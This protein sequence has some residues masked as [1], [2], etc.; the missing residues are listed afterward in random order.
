[1]LSSLSMFAQQTLT[2]IVRDLTAGENLPGVN[3]VVKGTTNGTSTDFDGKFQLKNIKTG[4]V[5][6]FSY[7]GYLNKEVTIDINFNI[8]VNLTEDSQK[9]DEVVIIGYGTT[10]LKDA[11]GSV[12]AI[13]A[14]DFTKGNIVTPENLLS[15]RVAG[16]NITTS[17]APGSGSQ[18]TIRGG[19][20]LGA[21]NAPLIVIDGLPIDNNGTAGSRGILANI[22]PNDIESF[23]IL[24]DA[25][26]TAIYGSRASNGVII[27]VTK[28]GK[29]EFTL[30]YDTQYSFGK[31]TDRVDVFSADE[32]R[33]FVNS[34]PISGTTLDTSLLGTANTNWQDEILQSTLSTQHNFTVKG[35]IL[36]KI[37][38]RVSL[39]FSN[40]EGA[41][42]T[43]QFNR[44]NFSL[45][46]NP[47]FFKDHLKIGLNYNRAHEDSRFAA[48]GIGAAL[49]YDPTHPVRVPG[50]PYG[51][52]Y[53]H[54]T[55][56]TDGFV[57]SNGTTN[58]V[59]SILQSTNTGN[60]FRQY[61]NL[62]LDYKFHF[63]PELKAVLNLGFD[64]TE[65]TYNN[66]SSL[67]GP[68]SWNTDVNGND[69]S[70]SQNRENKLLDG[71]LNYTKTF[72]D[73]KTDLTAGYSY[74]KFTNAGFNGR[75]LRDPNGISDAYAATDVVLIGYFGRANFTF[76]EKYLLTLSYRRD[77]TS[78]FSE[79]NRWGNFPAAAFAWRISD[80][81]F[82]KDSKVISELKLRASYG[83]TGQQDIPNNEIY[84]STYRFG[85]TNSR[86]IFGGNPI[87][88]TIPQAINPDIKWEETATLEFGL[89]YG[90]FDNKFT[91]SIGVFQKNS[92]D[93]L[94][95]APV[96]D[97]S[98]FTNSIV[99]NI[100]ELEVKGLEFTLNTDIIKNDDT[101]WNLNFNATYLD[102]KIKKLA[103]GQDVTT[104]GVA[105]GTGN[106]VQLFREGFAPNSFYVYK[107]LYDTAGNPI[108]GAYLDRTGDGIINGE[109]RY[110]KESPG[111]DVTLGMQSSFSYKN[112]DIAFNLRASIGNYNYN[113]VNSSQAQLSLLQDNAVLGNIP[114]SVLDTNFKVT[115]DVILSDMYIEN[116]SFLKMDNITLGYTFDRP[117]KAFTTNSVRLWAGVQNVFTLTNYS[118]LDPEVFNGIDNLIFPRS[119]TFLLGANIKF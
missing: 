108:E 79:E 84:L 50:T 7:L 94:F 66:V 18:I 102:R 114:T 81:D 46:M 104:G 67:Y 8:T 88:S 105:G 1:M 70:G 101:N 31:V 45:A 30:D 95:N 111:A 42:L 37:P 59:A 20:S 48:G 55:T 98:N 71:Y 83:I 118:G 27:I 99:Q 85:N 117:F 21:S 34:Q 41:I 17:G 49:R 24:K 77:G 47:T 76:L 22:N 33:A 64:K 19:S 10:T 25:S 62:N 12:E 36:N 119:R 35:S 61:G 15:G 82:L 23:S 28:K 91:G 106:T 26:A 57:L 107:Q 56:T 44:V 13:T 96:A 113:N 63:L 68:R 29:N 5:L 2:G 73:I 116:A 53:Q 65:G 14:K 69:S 80:E 43:S 74:Q 93:L 11:T 32:Y 9:L 110:L 115:S 6:V 90:L 75:N 3:V 58:P 38:T 4:D 100:G 87:Q 97:G 103:L 51:G 60:V 16:V 86:Y 72:N 109:D 39:G 112:F 52:Y 40:Q 54:Y 92:T 78:R 89:D